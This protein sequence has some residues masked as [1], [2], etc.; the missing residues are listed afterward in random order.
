MKPYS[1]RRSELSTEGDIVPLG[2]RVVVP[3]TLRKDVLRVLHAGHPGIVL[4]KALSRFYVW[5]P[6]IGSDIENYIQQCEY[7]QQYRNNEPS[8]PLHNWSIPLQPWT[9]IC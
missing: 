6:K 8:H 2:A 4:M 9:R 7:C 5:W 1:C 3:S